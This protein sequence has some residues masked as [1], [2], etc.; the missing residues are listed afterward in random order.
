VTVIKLLVVTWLTDLLAW[1]TKSG[2]F[3]LSI[4]HLNIVRILETLN[5]EKYNSVLATWAPHL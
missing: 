3:G 5:I 4:Y 2:G 1:L